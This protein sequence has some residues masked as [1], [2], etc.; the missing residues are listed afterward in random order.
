MQDVREDRIAD[1]DY[2]LIFAVSHIV[3]AGAI[4]VASLYQLSNAIKLMTPLLCMFIGGL[5]LFLKQKPGLFLASA[6]VIYISFLALMSIFGLMGGSWTNIH[7]NRLLFQQATVH[8]FIPLTAYG[9]AFLISRMNEIPP[10]LAAFYIV[11]ISIMTVF[12]YKYSGQAGMTDQ[13]A[14]INNLY[15][16]EVFRIFFIGILVYLIRS[17]FLFLITISILFFFAFSLQAKLCVSI[18]LIARFVP[19]KKWMLFLGFATG[20]V[21][22]LLATPFWAEL[23]VVEHNFGAR[24][25]F[26]HNALVALWDTGFLGVGYGTESIIPFYPH[27]GAIR[28]F[29]PVMPSEYSKIGVHSS[30]FQILFN[31]G[32]IGF[33]LLSA[34]IYKCIDRLAGMD[35]TVAPLDTLAVG[36]LCVSIFTNMAFDSYNFVIGS[37][38]LLGWIIYRGNIIQDELKSESRDLEFAAVASMNRSRSVKT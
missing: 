34:W 30:F 3:F 16:I 36:M 8:M 20:S 35:G 10:K 26:W 4:F 33:L 1:R 29:G 28:Y 27:N 13:V 18:I 38:F 5:G 7:S 37:T 22:A 2:L 32:L 24:A 17:N 14:I 23:M 11:P 15:S 25:L 31:A 6:F 12:I 9:F 21:L 19:I